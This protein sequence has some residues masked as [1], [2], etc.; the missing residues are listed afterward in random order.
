MANNKNHILVPIDF[1]EQSKI[2]LGQSLNIARLSKASVTLIYVIEQHFHLPFSKKV[3]E[4]KALTKNIQK[5]LKR[6]ADEN[7][8]MTGVKTDTLIAR[9]KVYE[10]IQNA[11]KK[12]KSSFIIMGTNG[13]G[14]GLKRFIGSNALRV[15]RESPCPVITIKGKKHRPGCKTILLPLDLTKE[16]KEKVGKAIEV[17]NLFGSHVYL[18]STLKTDDEFVVNKLKRQMIS[19]ENFLKENKVNCSHEFVKGDDESTEVIKYAKKIK[20]DLIMIMTQEE[21]NWTRMFIG[22]E[23]IQIIDGTDVPVLSIRPK[24]KNTKL[25]SP[26]EY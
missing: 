1:S 17:A 20:A 18:L 10:E 8:S 22:S 19:V 24:D 6:L 3:V 14:D 26:F 2:A 7:T 13:A 5:E 11:A 16:T 21:M 15:I 4:D 25:L 23:A 12:L 9:G